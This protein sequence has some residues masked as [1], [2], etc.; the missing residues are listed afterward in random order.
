MDR[1]VKEVGRSLGG[2]GGGG[3]SGTQTKSFKQG[4][5]IFFRPD[6]PRHLV[7]KFGLHTEVKH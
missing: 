6:F 4:I 5:I 2:G 1:M 3:V 7:D